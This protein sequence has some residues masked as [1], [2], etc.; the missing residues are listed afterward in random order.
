MKVRLKRFIA[1][2]KQSLKLKRKNDWDDNPF[3]IF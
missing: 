3:I 1:F 2:I